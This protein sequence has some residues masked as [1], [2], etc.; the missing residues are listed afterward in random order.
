MRKLAVTLTGQLGTLD[1]NA[2][3]ITS[4][5]TPYGME[6]SLDERYRETQL[7]FN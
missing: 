1:S 2:E 7:S 4:K 5:V 6:I 3:K